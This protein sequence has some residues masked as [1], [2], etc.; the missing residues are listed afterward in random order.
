MLRRTTSI[1]ADTSTQHVRANSEEVALIRRIATGD[2]RAFEKLYRDYFPRLT[3]FLYRMMRRP[4][5]VEEIVNDT[6]LVVSQKAA[7]FDS[8]ARVSTWIFSIAYRKGLKALRDL[9]EPVEAG[10]ELGCDSGPREELMRQQLRKVLFEAVHA[11]SVDHR[12]VIELTYF[13]GAGYREIAAIMGC[14]VD[15]VKTRMFHARRRLKALLPDQMEDG[16]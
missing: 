6:M 16:S 11:L 7:A 14:P 8:S 3:R 4:A 2:A 12:T 1:P 5:L 13:H 15:T 10:P 9:D